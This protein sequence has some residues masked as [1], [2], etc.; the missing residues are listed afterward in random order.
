LLLTEQQTH[1]ATSLLPLPG[2]IT[3]SN[4]S[5]SSGASR[6]QP[7]LQAKLHLLL[8][9]LLLVMTRQTHLQAQHW[10]LG[11]QAYQDCCLKMAAHPATRS[12]SSSCVV[13][14][15]HVPTL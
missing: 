9:P 8:R 6:I 5:S 4:S 3:S 7:Q 14:L 10:H 2:C 13:Q 1:S 11:Q 15:S 12:S